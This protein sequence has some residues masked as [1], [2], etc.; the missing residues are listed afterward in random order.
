MRGAGHI[1]LMGTE[2]CV[3]K[4]LFRKT[5]ME[6]TAVNSQLSGIQAS[7]ILMNW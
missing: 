3:K 1:T 4:I 6:E 2:K 5:C 7:K